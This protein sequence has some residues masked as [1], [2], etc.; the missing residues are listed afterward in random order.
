MF[1]GKSKE[2]KEAEEEYRKVM[3]LTEQ[4][5]PQGAMTED[6]IASLGSRVYLIMDPT[7]TEFLNPLDADGKPLPSSYREMYPAFSH[8]NRLSHIGKL[9]AEILELDYEYLMLIRKM[10]MDEDEY[11][12]K[13]WLEIESLKIHATHIISDAFDG[14]KGKLFTEQSKT[15]RTEM[16]ETKKKRWPF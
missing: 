5:K 11:D 12:S 1:D 14:W 8:L 15:I 10:N 4:G 7:V 9:Q 16:V 2:K 13:G 6:Y 3:A